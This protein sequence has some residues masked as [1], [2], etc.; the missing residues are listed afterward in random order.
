MSELGEDI[1]TEIG[2]IL[3]FDGAGE[4]LET[5]GIGKALTGFGD[6]F[7][8]DVFRVSEAALPFFDLYF[9]AT[10]F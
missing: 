1:L 2:F 4:G 6:F 9:M 10:G 5:T 3:L 8:G 7:C